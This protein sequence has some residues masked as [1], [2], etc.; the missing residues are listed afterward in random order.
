MCTCVWYVRARVRKRYEDLRGWL[1]IDDESYFRTKK[2]KRE[3]A[4]EY[5]QRPSCTKE[6]RISYT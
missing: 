3:D 2:N 6:K 4:E 5:V 1:A